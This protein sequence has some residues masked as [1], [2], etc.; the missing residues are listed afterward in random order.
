MNPSR[1]KESRNGRPSTF[2]RLLD[3]YFP[4]SSTED[5]EILLTEPDAVCVVC[6]ADGPAEPYGGPRSV[7]GARVARAVHAAMVTRHH[8]ARARSGR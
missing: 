3:S 5:S 7:W 2:P 8:D 6:P 1:T 4:T